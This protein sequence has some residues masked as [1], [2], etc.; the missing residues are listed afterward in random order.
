[1][2]IFRRRANARATAE[3]GGYHAYEDATF[4][5]TLASTDGPTPT[6]QKHLVL[7]NGRL[8][9]L[10][11]IEWERLQGFPDDWTAPAAYGA[12]YKQLG[13]AMNVDLAYWLGRRILAVNATLPMLASVA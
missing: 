12:R 1:V 6:R 8:R 4:F 9:G 10:T 2:R 13:D 5:N 3:L 11:P 7:Q